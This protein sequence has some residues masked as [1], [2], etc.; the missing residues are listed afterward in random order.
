MFQANRELMGI[1]DANVN[2][3]LTYFK[4]VLDQFFARYAEDARLLEYK[5][6]AE[7]KLDSFLAA[8]KR[9]T[10]SFVTGKPVNREVLMSEKARAQEFIIG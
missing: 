5:K 4:D 2:V 9:E 10:L 1:P 6:G 7:I 3:E 8:Y